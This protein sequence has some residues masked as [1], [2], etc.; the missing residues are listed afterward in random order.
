MVVTRQTMKGGR[1]KNT[2]KKIR[3]KTNK[4]KTPNISGMKKINIR[5][6]TIKKGVNIKSKKQLKKGVNKSKQRYGRGTRSCF[7][8]REYTNFFLLG[9][10]R[11][12]Y[13]NSSDENEKVYDNII[14]DVIRKFH[15]TRKSPFLKYLIKE[16]D[17][18][19]IS[20]IKAIRIPVIRFQEGALP[21]LNLEHTIIRDIKKYERRSYGK[22]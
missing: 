17:T 4:S 21:T 20:T 1:V 7:G 19:K 22:R 6:K 10:L 2:I 11:C 9:K 18:F 8:M 13:E 14:N 3:A 15:S 16:Y 12:C 5:T